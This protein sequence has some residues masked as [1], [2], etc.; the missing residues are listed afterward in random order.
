[1]LDIRPKI[2]TGELLQLEPLNESHRNDLYEAAQDET[3]WTYNGSKAYGEKFHHWFD[4]AIK[5][6]SQ[7]LQLPFAVRRLSDRKVIGS[8]RYYDINSDHH[9]LTVGYTWYVPSVWGTYVNPESKLLLLNFAFE[10][11]QVNRVEFVTD[12]R[13]V[14][15]RAAIKKLGAIE[16]GIL[17]HHMILEDGTMRDTVMFSIIKPDWQQ[18]KS[19]LHARLHNMK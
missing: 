16:E 8:T 1:M 13:N 12:A 2:L 9:R 10:G 14:R 4:K 19:Q 15:S 5:C 17:R 18:V 11:L 7:N 6:L 3:I